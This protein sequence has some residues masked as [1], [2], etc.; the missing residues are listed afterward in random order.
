VLTT[1]TL[2]RLR[3]LYPQDPFEVGRFRPTRSVPSALPETTRWPSGVN[4]T[5]VTE[6]ADPT[7]VAMS[8]PLT[9]SH[10]LSVPSVLPET[11]R[12]PSVVALASVGVGV[13]ALNDWSRHKSAVFNHR[14]S[15]SAL[16]RQSSRR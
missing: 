1:A 5:H 7:M 9:R 14:A 15:R 12:E 4:P 16:V 10:N 11:R 6:L 3:E 2:N 13:G 8:L